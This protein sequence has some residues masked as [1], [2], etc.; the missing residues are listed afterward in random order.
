M[1]ADTLHKDLN[2]S[3][4]KILDYSHPV[5]TK[6]YDN[7]LIEFY[8]NNILLPDS[9]VNEQESHGFITYT[10]MP[11]SGL[12]EQ[13]EITNT[14]YIYFDFNPAIVTNTTEN[15]MVSEILGI[16]NGGKMKK[17]PLTTYPNPAFNILNVE[18]KGNG[19]STIVIQSIDGK[20]VYTGKELNELGQVDVTALDN[21]MYLVT[22]VNGNKTY[23]TTFVKN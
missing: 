1:V 18:L 19:V 13:T 6:M 21:G 20:R 5:T 9:N 8:F 14:A 16:N 12:S 17:L 11:D 22:V 10:I 2:W 7:G 3:T 15:I 4:F 23:T